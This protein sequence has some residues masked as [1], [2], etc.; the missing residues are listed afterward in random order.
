VQPVCYSGSRVLALLFIFQLVKTHLQLHQA[1]QVNTHSPTNSVGVGDEGL[2]HQQQQRQQV[3]VPWLLPSGGMNFTVLEELISQVHALLLTHPGM[4][5]DALVTRMQ[6]ALGRAHLRIF[7]RR[8][9]ENNHLRCSTVPVHA[10][11]ALAE[12][13]EGVKEGVLAPTEDGLIPGIFT[14]V[15]DCSSNELPGTR[16]PLVLPLEHFY[17][18]DVASAVE[19]ALRARDGV[20]V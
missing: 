13:A 14:S 1:L 8:M 16:P 10:T 2:P 6:H 4:P 18:S 17:F 15:R 7:L 20:W 9:C 19:G 11:C 12:S 5:E 3:A